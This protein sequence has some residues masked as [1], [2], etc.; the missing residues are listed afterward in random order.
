[1]RIGN[2]DQTEISPT[3]K[4]VADIRRLPTQL[5]IKKSIIAAN[6]GMMAFSRRLPVGEL[7]RKY[8]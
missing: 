7:V 2:A 3:R 8:P 6:T 1:M 5:P 4:I